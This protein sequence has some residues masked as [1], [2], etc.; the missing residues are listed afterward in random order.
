MNMQSISF[1]GTYKNSTNYDRTSS[2]P[3]M[4]STRPAQ[5]Y[6]TRQARPNSN[7]YMR[8]QVGE[9]RS[10]QRKPKVD[11]SI[12]TDIHET[13]RRDKEYLDR[14][15]PENVH[16]IPTHLLSFIAGITSALLLNFGPAIA[17]PTKDVAKV[18]F[19]GHSYSLTDIA[20]QYGCDEEIIRQYNGIENNDDLRDLPVILVPTEYN[21]IDDEI[22]NLQNSLYSSKLSDEERNETEEKISALKDK[23]AKQQQVAKV[24]TDGKYIYFIINLTD[25]NGNPVRGGINVETFKELFDIKDGQIR[26]YNKLD[27]VWRKD[28][29]FEEDKGYYDYTG[30]VFYTGDVI[31]ISDNGVDTKDIDLEDFI[32]E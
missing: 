16:K 2:N 26:K 14:E 11:K 10:T 23:K 21:Y 8:W 1:M 15:Y 30:N 22:E 18:P 32:E 7:D 31:K 6:E 24:Y 9:D 29:D 5:N 20:E 19:D 3:N 12:M 17:Q 25:E 13:A 28:T 4:R 27:S